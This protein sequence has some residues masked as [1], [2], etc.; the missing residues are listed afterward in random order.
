MANVEA[1]LVGAG[2]AYFHGVRMSAAEA[3]ARA[4]LQPLQNQPGQ[5]ERPGRRSPPTMRP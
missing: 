2:E 5:L 4:G 1:T 3:L